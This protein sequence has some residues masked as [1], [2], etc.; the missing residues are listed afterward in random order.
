MGWLAFFI[1]RIFLTVIA[2]KYASSRGRNVIGWLFFCIFLSPLIALIALYCLKDLNAEKAEMQE[3][4]KSQRISAAAF[5]EQIKALCSLKEHG[6]INGS[7]YEQ[8]K[9]ALVKS[10]AMNGIKDSPE[11]FLSSLIPLKENNSLNQNDIDYIK[12]CLYRSPYQA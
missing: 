8:K 12:A 9:V 7:E 2:C 5:V 4:I 1:V 3:R 10:L 11:L 6:M